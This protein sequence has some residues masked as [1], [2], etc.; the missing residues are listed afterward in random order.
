[1]KTFKINC[2]IILAFLY[3]SLTFA[4]EKYAGNDT[5]LIDT[6]KNTKP[7]IN[8]KVEKEYDEEGNIIRYDSIYT[9]FHSDEGNFSDS[10]LIIP[11]PFYFSDFLK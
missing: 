3:T 6:L 1:M 4:Y 8:I 10:I 7:Q 5:M 11:Q 9:Y 2:L